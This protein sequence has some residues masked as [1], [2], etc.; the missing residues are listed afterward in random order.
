MRVL[1]GVFIL[2]IAAGT[3]YGSSIGFCVLGAGLVISRMIQRN[4]ED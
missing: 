4:I 3:E 2:S 1:L